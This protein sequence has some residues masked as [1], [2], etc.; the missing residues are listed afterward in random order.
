M[1]LKQYIKAACLFFF[2]SSDNFL[3]G[4]GTIVGF[5]R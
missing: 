1:K 4:F 2:R 5:G 3:Y